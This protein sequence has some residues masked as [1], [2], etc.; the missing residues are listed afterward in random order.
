MKSLPKKSVR[1]IFINRIW[2]ADERDNLVGQLTGQLVVHPMSSLF[3]EN[4]IFECVIRHILWHN[5]NCG[6]KIMILNLKK[7]S[8]ES[9]T[10]V[11]L[12]LLTNRMKPRPSIG[13]WYFKS[14]YLYITNTGLLGLENILNLIRN[15][16]VTLHTT[17]GDLKIELFVSQTPKTCENFLALCGTDYYNSTNWNN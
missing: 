17:H 10:P 11:K 7:R 3:P 12:K 16:A 13:V 1:Q 14:L 15:M 2:D 8:Q 4:S 9:R 5:S 6:E